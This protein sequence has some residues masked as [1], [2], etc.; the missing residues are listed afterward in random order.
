MRAMYVTCVWILLMGLG[1]MGC[2][3]QQ[4]GL[5]VHNPWVEAVPATETTAGIYMGIQNPN[6]EAKVLAAAQSDRAVVALCTMPIAG[7]A[8]EPEVIEEI[9]IPAMGR[10][11]LTPDGMHLRLFDLTGELREG[12]ALA[13]T[14]YF[15]DGGSQL[16]EAIVKSPQPSE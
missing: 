10:V 9:P 15:K 12:D 4:E 1:A 2:G 16:I 5:N 7:E 13:I 6:T 8:S 3:K 11:D 14:L